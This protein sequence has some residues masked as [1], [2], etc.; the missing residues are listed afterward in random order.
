[1]NFG[2]RRSNIVCT[3]ALQTRLFMCVKTS[4]MLAQPISVLV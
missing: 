1:M 2:S 3:V 4:Y